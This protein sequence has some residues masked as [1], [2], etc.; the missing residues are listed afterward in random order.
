M[1]NEDLEMNEKEL[2]EFAEFLRNMSAEDFDKAT[3]EVEKEIFTEE[4]YNE[5][6]KE[7]E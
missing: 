5:L 7:S 3:K 6:N 4:F 1:N 2:K